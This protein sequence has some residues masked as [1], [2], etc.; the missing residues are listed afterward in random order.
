M[1]ETGFRTLMRQTQKLLSRVLAALLVRCRSLR[2]KTF[3]RKV[4]EAQRRKD[5]KPER[6]LCAFA[7]LRLCVKNTI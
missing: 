1:N 4:A 3:Q 2:T 6:T 7:P 5:A